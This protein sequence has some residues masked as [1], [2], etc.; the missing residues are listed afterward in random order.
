MVF[1]IEFYKDGSR[2]GERPVP[3]TLEDAKRQA[4]EGLVTHGADFA[5]V[6]DQDGSGAEVWSVRAGTPESKIN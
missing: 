3:G 1:R 2:F 5:R 6:I 4:K